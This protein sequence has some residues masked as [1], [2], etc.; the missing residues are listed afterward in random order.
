MHA[1]V[2]LGRERIGTT[3]RRPRRI[4]EK[5]NGEA[6]R[7]CGAR[8]YYLVFRVTSGEGERARLAA[9]C[10]RCHE[11]RDLFSIEQLVR[12]MNRICAERRCAA[13]G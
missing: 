12:D 9:R 1:S 4:V 2:N 10:S 8:H 6:C 13:V 7:C 5:L 11:Q 3:G